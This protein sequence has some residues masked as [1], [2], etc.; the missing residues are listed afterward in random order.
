M[1]QDGIYWLF[2]SSAQTVAAFVA[3]LLAG[4]ALS[5]GML[6]GT[7]Q[8]DETMAEVVEELKRGYHNRV[9]DLSYLT[10]LA[11]V[12]NL[13]IVMLQ[14]VGTFYHWSLLGLGAGLNVVAIG[15]AIHF[16]VGLINPNR[17]RN[18]ARRLLEALPIPTTPEP[19]ASVADFL[20]MFIPLERK[21]RDLAF[22]V[23]QEK[24]ISSIS[25]EQRFISFPRIVQSL[26]IHE[27]ISKSEAERILSLA[28]YRNLVVH[29]Q[30]ESV[31]QE[32]VNEAKD[33]LA[34]LN[35]RGP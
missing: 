25:S 23:T 28:R 4:F 8:R 13:L 27:M 3:F 26:V 11:I 7:I 10:G 35:D 33:I 18:A 29:G 34:L 17:V 22:G 16:T 31:E 6:D 21:L 15:L 30:V 9:R 24:L 32:M 5:L 14:A 2:T 12:T 19:T 1:T 20:A